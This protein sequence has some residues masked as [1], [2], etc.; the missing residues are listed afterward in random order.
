MTSDKRTNSGGI[1]SDLLLGGLVGA[2]SK[3]AMAPVERIK[4]L[5]Q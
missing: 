1:A 2:V 5:M 4:L 3:T